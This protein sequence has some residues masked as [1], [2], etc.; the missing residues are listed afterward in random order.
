MQT[1]E[2]RKLK[3][4]GKIPEVKNAI[5]NLF[6]DTKLDESEKS[7]LLSIAILFINQYQTDRRY[8]SYMDFAYSIILKYSL[9]TLDFKPLYDISIN[10]GFYPIANDILKYELLESTN[11]EDSIISGALTKFKNKSNFIETL[12]QKNRKSSFLLDSSLERSYLAPTSFGKSALIV[13]SIKKL[14]SLSSKIVVVVQTKSL[15]MQT[16]QLIRGSNLGR[17]IIIHDEMYDDENDFIA[18]FTQERALRLMSRKNLSYDYLFIDEAHNILNFDSRSILLSRLISKNKKLNL[19]QKVVYLSPLIDNIENVKVSKEQSISTHIIEHN[20]KEPDLFEYTLEGSVR[21]YNRFLDTF[22]SIETNDNPFKYTIDKSKSKNFVYNYRPIR[23][24]EFTKEFST[25]LIASKMSPDIFE[26]YNTLKKEVHD[27]FYAIDYLKYGIVYIHGKLPDLIKEYIEDKYRKLPELKY[28]VANS[29]ILEGMNLPIDSLFIYNTRG[30]NGKELINLIGRVNRLNQIFNDNNNLH[31]LIP[32]IHFVNTEFYNKL[33]S[34]ME[35][36]IREL[37]SRTFKDYVN[38]PILSNFDIENQSRKKNDD[39]VEKVRQI[40]NN[41]EF[42]SSIHE[43]QILKLRAYLIESGI[44]DHYFD[45]RELISSV[46]QK[47]RRIR[48]NKLLGEDINWEEFTM[49]EKI[50]FLFVEG[51]NSID[52]YEIK[53]LEYSDT[54]KYYEN[55]ILVGRKKSLKENIN[56]QFKFFKKKANSEE[57]KMYFGGAYGEEDYQLN[58]NNKVFVNLKGKTDRK[59]INL[60]IV[61]LKMEEDFISFKLNKLIVM[62]YDYSL[63]DIDEYNLYI[64]GTNDKDKIALTKYGL[65]IRLIS[66]LTEDGQLKNLSFDIYNNLI[67]NKE[68]LKFINKA[69]DFYKFEISRF[70]N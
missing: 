31:K 68:F 44:I 12:E 52:D 37:R 55:F 32:S 70:L 29:V 13:T 42:I 47:I 1:E 49:L 7:F 8:S 53:R 59:L 38:N 25:Y 26:L 19:N 45:D 56:S 48:L 27:E 69:D 61:K 22:Y 10:L 41:E 18:V 34:K 40:Q 58:G 54:R 6:T 57:P 9:K 64:Y 2:K 67:A 11:F 39:F 65:N 14:G 50:N 66:R 36:K 28:I 51:I 43:T 24:E 16:Y 46:F 3:S 23:I 62:L 60:A 20:I 21:L 15:L 63:I 17:K 4:I 30:L 33:G 35:N 5:K